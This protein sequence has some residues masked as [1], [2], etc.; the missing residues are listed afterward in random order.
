MKKLD[1]S[2]SIQFPPVVLYLE[3]LEE[4]EHVLVRDAKDLVIRCEGYEFDS[5]A[6]LAT[7]LDGKQIH[8]MEFRADNPYTSIDFDPF[9]TRIHVGTSNVHGAGISHLIANILQRRTRSFRWI[10]KPWTPSLLLFG[11]SIGSPLLPTPW[12]RLLYV[13]VFIW[14]LWSFWIDVKRHSIIRLVKRP[15]SFFA[16]NR[17]QLVIT[18]I[19][20][21]IGAI[22]TMAATHLYSLLYP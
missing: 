8:A 7:K 9:S 15:A 10:Y 19:S 17:D 1:Q 12:N 20:A 3:D 11:I 22:L 13:L 21:V 5:T 2:I 18:I 14:V 6:E 16:R 4:I